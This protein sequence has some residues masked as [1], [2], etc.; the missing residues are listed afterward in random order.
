MSDDKYFYLHDR[1]GSVRQVVN[2]SGVVV[3]DY[4]YDPYGQTIESSGTF[5]NPFQFTGQYFD[6]EI[7]EYYLRARQYNPQIA[8]FTSRDPVRGEFDEP[9]I[10]HKYLY[11]A[12]DPINKIDPTGRSLWGQV[13][14][15]MAGYSVHYGAIGFAAYG[16][17]TGNERFLTLGI[18]MKY[19]I[20]PVMALVLAKQNIEDKLRDIFINH[21]RNISNNISGNFDP[22]GKLPKHIALALG[23]LVLAE[24]LDGCV[25]DP[26]EELPSQEDWDHLLRQ[27]DIQRF[28]KPPEDR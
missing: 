7:E 23:L 28:E 3:K 13:E 14:A 11:C 16:V 10:L 2:D 4:A 19:T 8:R 6:S 26:L 20:L 25:Q 22:R 5:D 15:V 24:S 21:D 1:L 27:D 12:N 17:G 18:K 9:L